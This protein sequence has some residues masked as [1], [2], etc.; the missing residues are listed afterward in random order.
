MIELRPLLQNYG[1]IEINLGKISIFENEKEDVVKISVVSPRLVQL[2][3]IINRHFE[4][5]ETHPDYIPHVTLAYVKPGLGKKYEGNGTFAGV[6]VIL[7]K[8][9]F[10]GNDYRETTFSMIN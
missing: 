2:N 3:S 10:S 6:K 1:P 8:A 9:E 4:N 5:T 7:D